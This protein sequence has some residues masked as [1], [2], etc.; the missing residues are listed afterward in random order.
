MIS[1]QLYR[2]YSDAKHKEIGYNT[3]WSCA[4]RINLFDDAY[5]DICQHLEKN[6]TSYYVLRFC[7]D[8]FENI[9]GSNFIIDMRSET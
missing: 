5:F 1:K 3:C 6:N 4:K 8:C 7:Y 9:A 2:K